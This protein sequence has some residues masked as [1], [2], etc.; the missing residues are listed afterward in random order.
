MELSTGAGRQNAR[1]RMRG[2]SVIHGLDCRIIAVKVFSSFNLGTE[3]RM[4]SDIR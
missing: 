2:L 1:M 4:V 3:R